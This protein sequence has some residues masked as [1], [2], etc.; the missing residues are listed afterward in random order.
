MRPGDTIFELYDFMSLDS[1]SNTDK[2]EQMEILTNLLATARASSWLISADI[3]NSGLDDPSF[4]NALWWHALDY[5]ALCDV[6]RSASASPESSGSVALDGVIVQ[7]ES[8]EAQQTQQEQQSVENPPAPIDPTHDPTLVAFSPGK[9]FDWNAFMNNQHPEQDL[10][11]PNSAGAGADMLWDFML[12]E[13]NEVPSAP[14]GYGSP[15]WKN[16]TPS[17]HV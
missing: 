1:R 13:N 12:E 16:L 7:D 17:Q 10:T 11:Q 3:D 14:M 6:K 2:F 4:D 9:D 15:F 8:A 5:S